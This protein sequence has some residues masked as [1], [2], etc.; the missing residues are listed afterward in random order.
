MTSASGF[1][2]GNE[3]DDLKENAVFETVFESFSIGVIRIDSKLK[4]YVIDNNIFYNL[5][6]PKN[7]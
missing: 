2:V 5:G 4:Y 3:V 7:H 6:L 1:G